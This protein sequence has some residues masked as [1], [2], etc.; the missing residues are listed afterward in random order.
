MKTR[1]V[2]GII[3]LMLLMFTMQTQA[4][5]KHRELNFN[6]LKDHVIVKETKD[7]KYEITLKVPKQ[8]EPEV[9][10]KDKLVKVPVKDEKITLTLSTEEM[11]N[12]VVRMSMVEAPKSKEPLIV[13]TIFNYTV[14]MKDYIPR[15][16]APSLAKREQARK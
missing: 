9:R 7:N 6:T 2:I 11:K 15:K 3:S 12:T 8:F 1:N 5:M 14:K 16:G 13:T 10:M 4:M